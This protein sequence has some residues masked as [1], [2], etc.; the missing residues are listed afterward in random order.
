[1]K[2]T[3]LLM[4]AGLMLLTQC[5]KDD[6][7]G[8]TPGTQTV[9]MTVTVGTGRTNIGD[10]GSITWS[11][12]DKLYVS[13]GAKCIGALDIYN[14]AN[15]ANCGPNY[16]VAKFHGSVN[17]ND[18]KDGQVFHFFYLGNG[19]NVTFNS[20]TSEK[21]YENA[22]SA[23]IG[24]NEQNIY[25]GDNDKLVNASNFHIG[26]GIETGTLTTTDDTK[27]ITITKAVNM[28]SKVAIAYFE[29]KDGTKDG[30]KD[31]VT[32]SGAYNQMTVNFG[33]VKSGEKEVKPDSEIFV[34]GYKEETQKYI[35]LTET[36]SSQRYVM[37][38]PTSFVETGGEEK[39]LT[40]SKNSTS[41]GGPTVE[42]TKGIVANHFYCKDGNL[43]DPIE[44]TFPN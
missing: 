11:E 10:N 1:M 44:V 42:F 19:D 26:Y 33:C 9:N 15:P 27:T 21:S 32:I 20:G 7:A 18:V 22:T 38:V 41:E 30:Y 31:K 34:G 28:S 2:K 43:K 3:L 40:F 12:N 16:S 37:L 39:T 29:F 25:K 4:V 8:V 17:L 14:E 24:F 5:R 35:T 13:D 6:L 23:T 36:S